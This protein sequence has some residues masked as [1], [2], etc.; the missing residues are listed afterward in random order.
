MF[1]KGVQNGS[2]FLSLHQIIH[3]IY[4]VTCRSVI[5]VLAGRVTIE[6][7]LCLDTRLVPLLAGQVIDIAVV[8]ILVGHYYLFIL[9]AISDDTV[10]NVIPK[11]SC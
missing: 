10:I 8:V 4:T 5:D 9:V 11:L 3:I 2:N 6:I 1:Q 7:T